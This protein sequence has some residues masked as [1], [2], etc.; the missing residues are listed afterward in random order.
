MM[1]NSEIKKQDRNKPA[2]YFDTYSFN[3]G[4]FRIISVLDGT[5]HADY[6]SILN[7]PPA[8]EIKTLLQ[9][10]GLQGSS[11]VDI[12]WTVFFIDTGKHK[13]L[14]DTG[15]SKTFVDFDPYRRIRLICLFQSHDLNMF[16]Y[17]G[18]PLIADICWKT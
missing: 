6:G 2:K 17:P 14:I 12:S 15:M 3:L 1:E 8:Q 5:L 18:I 16:S 9:T 13:V 11:P 7:G 10:R 4:D